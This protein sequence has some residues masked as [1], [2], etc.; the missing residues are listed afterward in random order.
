[1]IWALF[2]LAGMLALLWPLYNSV[3]PIPDFPRNLWP[4]VVITWIVAGVL[5]PIVRP[6]LVLADDGP[7]GLDQRHRNDG[8]H[9]R[10]SQ[11]AFFTRF[12]AFFFACGCRAAVRDQ[13]GCYQPSGP[14]PQKCDAFGVNPRGRAATGIATDTGH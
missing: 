7:I 8:V 4:Y 13:R 1:L 2:G 5:L 6:A 10:Q 3:Y 9:E 11:Q 14:Q 12:Q